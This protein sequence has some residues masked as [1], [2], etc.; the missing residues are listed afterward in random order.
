LAIAQFAEALLVIPKTLA[1]NAALD[2]TELVSKLRAHHNAAQ[3]D[4]KKRHLAMFVPQTPSH[5]LA[6]ESAQHHSHC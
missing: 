4:E 3:T 2:A 1:V 5:T 6:T